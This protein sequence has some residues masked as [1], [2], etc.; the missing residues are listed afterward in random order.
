MWTLSCVVLGF[1]GFTDVSFLYPLST[2]IRIFSFLMCIKEQFRKEKYN[3]NRQEDRKNI[4]ASVPS[5]LL[6][7]NRLCFDYLVIVGRSTFDR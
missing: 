6:C 4:I 7:K 5:S 1:R 3:K 2:R